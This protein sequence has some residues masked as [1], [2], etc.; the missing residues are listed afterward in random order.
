[1]QILGKSAQELNPIITSGADRMKE[2]GEQ[3]H[4]AG[5]VLSDE[6]LNAYGA[7]D[8]QLQYLKNGSTALKNALGTILLPILTDLATDG[9]SLLSEFHKRNKGLQW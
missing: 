6:M 5:Y 9:V 1:M 4:E 2:L 7:L 8:D 3:A